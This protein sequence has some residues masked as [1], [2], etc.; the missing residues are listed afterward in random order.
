MVGVEAEDDHAFN[1]LLACVARTALLSTASKVPCTGWTS[2][3]PWRHAA[4]FSPGTPAGQAKP[5]RSS[6]V[7]ELDLN[8]HLTEVLPEIDR[9]G[10]GNPD[11]PIYKILLVNAL[12]VVET[13][14]HP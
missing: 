6:S 3:E 12:H 7:P 14:H 9:T 1:H 8:E 4:R 5:E 10:F 11:I 2:T 13:L